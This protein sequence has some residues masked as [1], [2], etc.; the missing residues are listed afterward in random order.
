VKEHDD[1]VP[2]LSG[3]MGV[4]SERVDPDGGVEGTGTTGSTQGRTSGA[5]PTYPDETVP[6]PGTTEPGRPRE[7]R[8]DNP[9]DVPAHA[10]DPASNPGHSHG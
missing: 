8:D 5:A 1:L 6:T 3:D 10:S 4:S 9:A 2:D 7:E